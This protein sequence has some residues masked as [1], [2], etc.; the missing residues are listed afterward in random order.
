MSL[1][2]YK[3]ITDMTCLLQTSLIRQ[4]AFFVEIT[5]NQVSHCKTL[6][7]QYLKTNIQKAYYIT[8]NVQ[9]VTNWNLS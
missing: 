7:Q 3:F 9:L 8:Y 6:S 1:A 5:N 2:P 4:Y